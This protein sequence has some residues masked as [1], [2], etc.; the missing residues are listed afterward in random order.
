M[1]PL[2]PLSYP[3][4]FQGNTFN[5]TG[6][7]EAALDSQFITFR[8]KRRG[9]FSSSDV[10][11]V[12]P[13]AEVRNVVRADTHIHVE[14]P[15]AIHSAYIG[16]V[17][18]GSQPFIDFG[19][20]DA[21]AADAIRER[22]PATQTEAFAEMV[23]EERDFQGSL[24]E[25]T[26]RA[27]VTTAIVAVNVAVFA[28]MV[29]AGAGVMSPDPRVHVRWGSNFGLLTAAGEW[30]RL[31]TAMFLHFGLLHLAL[32][33]W[34]LW[35]MGR[36]VERIYGN[37]TYLAMYLACGVG[38][39]LTSLLWHPQ[40]NS[41]GASGAIFGVFG[42]FA[43]YLA[44]RERGVPHGVIRR[45]WGSTASFIGYN[46]FLGATVPGIDNAA[47]VGGLVCG[48]VLGLA[49]AR[50]LD[51]QARRYDPRRLAALAG[52][53]A[54]A[55]WLV[56]SPLADVANDAVARTALQGAIKDFD[57]VVTDAENATGEV[58]QLSRAHKID[59]RDA[60]A[61]LDEDVVKR[62]DLAYRRLADS[63][64]PTRD[65]A[66][67]HRRDQLMRFA[68]SRRDAFQLFSASMRDNNDASLAE[69]AKAR[70][71]DGDRILEQ[72]KTE[73]VRQRR[74]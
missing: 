9:F 19:V 33:M 16:K 18:K 5:L 31:F 49:L 72:I 36:V 67:A 28:A 4:R 46:L 13:L 41:A 6:K 59:D 7:G 53:I 24:T 52:A 23:R 63:P 47:H 71:T 64:A 70:L 73:S 12:F 11:M 2:P 3:V 39:S 1:T 57:R 60:A 17:P 35:E 27:Y 20:E 8:G 37:L 66:L 51:P 25:V 43:A 61:R 40:V 45:R 38:A 54:V 65:E 15:F 44:L 10:E 21:A 30:W 26:P 32:N 55:A 34:A 69:R 62:Y 74:R 22:L 58:I 56:R 50:P 29:L 14:I 48:F 68:E 42:A